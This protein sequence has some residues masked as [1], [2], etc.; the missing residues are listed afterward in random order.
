ML[1]RIFGGF[2]AR[3]LGRSSG[4]T[5]RLV[6]GGRVPIAGRTFSDYPTPLAVSAMALLGLAGTFSGAV[7]SG[8]AAL[9][10]IAGRPGERS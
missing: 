5:V 7:G 8:R 4:S 9:A 6:C 2:V 1:A 10:T 3:I